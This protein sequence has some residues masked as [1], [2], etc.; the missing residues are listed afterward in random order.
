MDLNSDFTRPV[1]VQAGQ[2]P[3]TASPSPGVERRMLDRIGGEVARATSIVRFAPG[4]S[5]S[6]HTHGG[7]E[8]FLVLEG[9]FQ[10]EHGDYP[11]GTYVRNPPTTRHTPGSRD[12]CTI[13]VKLWQFDP[14]DRTQFHRPI[15]EGLV[16]AGP[17][18]RQAVLHRD[19]RET[20]SHMVLAPGAALN[21]DPG[22]GAELLVLSGSLS[23][24]G[25]EVLEPQG[26]LRLPVGAPLRARAGQEGAAL[27]MK[28]GHLRFV[29]APDV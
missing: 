6:P 5:F 1:R 28:T 25:G 8:E 4:H 12:G 2:L 14:D 16:P 10:D 27:W 11:A 3:W 20:V 29:A 9:V 15:V 24:G 18:V 17:G 13:F 22:G 7:G 19:A 26:W 23:D 21:L